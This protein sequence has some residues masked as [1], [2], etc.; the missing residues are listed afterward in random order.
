L[1]NDA[2]KRGKVVVLARGGRGCLLGFVTTEIGELDRLEQ[3][4]LVGASDVVFLRGGTA[5]DAGQGE[6]VIFE[7]FKLLRHFEGDRVFD[8]SG[9]G[10]VF[11]GIECNFL[12]FTLIVDEGY[13]IILIDVLD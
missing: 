5:I 13:I 4:T 2:V 10:F 12:G 8:V 9:R 3:S 6:D 11:F 1:G 7:E